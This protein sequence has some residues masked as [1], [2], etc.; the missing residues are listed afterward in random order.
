MSPRV[1]AGH[2][3]GRRLSAPPG[4]GTRPTSERV[5]EA[6]FSML[7]TLDGEAV[8]DLFAGSGALGVEAL[9]R[10]AARAVFVERSHGAL[11][12]LV[13]NMRDL[14][15]PGEQA[16]LRRGD[17]ARVLRT[18]RDAHETYDLVFI[19]PPYRHASALG[20]ELSALLPPLLSPVARVITE[21]DRRDPLGL[22]LALG[23]ERRYG[24]TLIRIYRH[25]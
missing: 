6:V 14:G 1:I 16:E 20:H 25:P 10:G 12:A 15:L 13:R 4:R 21:S 23:D 24:D 19:D 9:S 11:A 17:V 5:R 2:L 22:N 3:G 18:A 8:L 7:G